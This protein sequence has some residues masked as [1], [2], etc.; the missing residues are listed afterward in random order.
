MYKKTKSSGFTILELMVCLVIIGIISTITIFQYRDYTTSIDLKGQTSDIAL[1]LRQA[2]VNATSGREVKP[3]TD[4]FRKSYIVVFD[5]TT[6]KYNL[7]GDTNG[8]GVFDAGDDL[9]AQNSIKPGYNLCI[10]NLPQ[11]NCVPSIT[12]FSVTYAFNS[13]TTVLKDLNPISPVANIKYAEFI[14]TKTGDPSNKEE[15]VRIWSTGRI[16]NT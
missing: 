14:V 4:N 6:K 15:R 10:T 3:G 9:I 13:Y 11:G 16:E 8:S 12:P 1:I 5:T 2:Q 7:Y